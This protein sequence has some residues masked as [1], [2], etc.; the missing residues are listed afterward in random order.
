VRLTAAVILTGGG[1][2]GLGLYVTH[3]NAGLHLTCGRSDGEGISAWSTT[4]CVPI[5]VSLEPGSYRLGA[6]FSDCTGYHASLS[7]D[8]GSTGDISHSVSV[9]AIDDGTGGVDP[10]LKTVSW[11]DF[12]VPHQRN[13]HLTGE[14]TVIATIDNGHCSID[15]TVTRAGDYGSANETRTTSLNCAPVAHSVPS[16]S[17]DSTVS[18]NEGGFLQWTW[19]DRP[20]EWTVPRSACSPPQDLSPGDYHTRATLTDCGGSIRWVLEDQPR[21]G[22]PETVTVGIDGATPTAGGSGRGRTT[23]YQADFSALQ[24]HHWQLSIASQPTHS[25]Y[26]NAACAITLTIV[27]MPSASTP[28][29][30]PTSSTADHSAAAANEG[31]FAFTTPGGADVVKRVAIDAGSYWLNAGKA[32]SS[33]TWSVKI[34]G[35]VAADLTHLGVTSADSSAEGRSGEVVVPT[36]KLYEI[37]MRS[38]CGLTAQLTWV[39]R[40]SPPLRTGPAAPNQ[41]PA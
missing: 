24:V 8:A 34:P 27:P 23:E 17:P 30:T 20:P 31:P 14:A 6:Q 11:A 16:F 40:P 32:P 18:S 10:S 36:S 4:T 21:V 9:G 5:P 15:V 2:A 19:R 28:S 33:C 12:A 26:D 13:F 39:P 25:S 3:Q 37:H 41:W 1:A 29:A 35:V 22:K 38:D 7:P